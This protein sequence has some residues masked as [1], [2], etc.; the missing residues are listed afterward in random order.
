MF[1]VPRR[2]IVPVKRKMASACPLLICLTNLLLSLKSCIYISGAQLFSAFP[3]FSPLGL[4]TLSINSPSTPR[5]HFSICQERMLHISLH[6][7]SCTPGP[8]SDMVAVIRR[9]RGLDVSPRWH[10]RLLAF[11]RGK[12]RTG[13]GRKGLR[14]RQSRD[15]SEGTSFARKSKLKGR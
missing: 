2:L 13:H 15:G 11:N 9:G 1:A 7:I 10:E 5:S 14:S 6:M 12:T 4:L 3:A 8:G